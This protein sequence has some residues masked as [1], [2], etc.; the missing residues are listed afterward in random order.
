MRRILLGIVGLSLWCG[1]PA[2]STASAATVPIEVR[3]TPG[4]EGADVKALTIR[5]GYPRA[6]LTLPGVADA[7][8]VKERVRLVAADDGH[9][10]LLVVNNQA[11][12]GV[13]RLVYMRQPIA[14]A[15]P[16]AEGALIRV[17]FDAGSGAPPA[18][19]LTC[20]V[21]GASDRSG[22][23]L[24]GVGCSVAIVAP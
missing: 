17:A 4:A 11:D 7:E 20:S 14:E 10:D 16:I 15:S 3:I 5:L 6:R 21:A 22:R 18:S 19:D 24:P 2:P 1:S 23:V 9:E 13:L 8:A 12:E